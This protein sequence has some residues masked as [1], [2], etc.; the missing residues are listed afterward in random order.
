MQ[1]HLIL[2]VSSTDKPGVIESLSSAIEACGGS[3]QE[4]RLAHLAGKFVGV[5]LIDIDEHQTDRLRSKL[6][7]L[8]QSGIAVNVETTSEPSAESQG[9]KKAKFSAIGPD[10]IGIVKEISSAFVRKGINVEE[11]ETNLSSMPYSGEPIFEAQGLISLPNGTDFK[12]LLDKL[13]AIANDLGLDL[14]LEAS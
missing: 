3:W 1:S 12:Q 10:R 9:L 4:S 5:I 2:S 14:D 7:Q 6:E 8:G 13:D 11:L